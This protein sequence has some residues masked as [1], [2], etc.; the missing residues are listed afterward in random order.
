[1]F[2]TLRYVPN[3]RNP[4]YVVQRSS[5]RVPGRGGDGGDQHLAC[6]RCRIKKVGS[7]TYYSSVWLRISNRISLVLY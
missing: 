3:G 5:D 7:L 4:G 1:M 2:G 6:D